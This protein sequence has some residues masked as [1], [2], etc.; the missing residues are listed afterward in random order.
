MMTVMK[1]AA[2]TL[3]VLLF[4]AT[5][6]LWSKHHSGPFKLEWVQVPTGFKA[7]ERPEGRES[8]W[9]SSDINIMNGDYTA[10]VGPVHF[11]EPNDGQPDYY[12][13]DV[14]RP[15]GKVFEIV[16]EIRVPLEWVSDR[17]L[18]SQAKDI[19]SFDP[20]SRVITYDLGKSIFKCKFVRKH[21]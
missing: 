9:R 17:A 11:D 10:G 19:V 16:A 15:D 20:F 18:S 7:F 3:V 6:Y 12:V 13:I 21:E 5:A 4:C 1:T 14:E 2:V 8:G